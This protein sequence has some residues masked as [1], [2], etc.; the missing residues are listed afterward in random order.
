M[1]RCPA[2]AM[3]IATDALHVAAQEYADDKHPDTDTGNGGRI[4]D[5]SLADQAIAEPQPTDAT[6]RNLDYPGQ[7]GGLKKIWIWKASFDNW[8]G[9][10]RTDEENK[11]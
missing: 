7:P 2:V 6:K 4:E 11:L 8:L 9:P 10:S 3:Q 5:R 1:L